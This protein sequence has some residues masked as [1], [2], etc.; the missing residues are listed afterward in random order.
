MN[1]PYSVDFE[2]NTIRLPT[3]ICELKTE[4]DRMLRNCAGCVSSSGLAYCGSDST[5]AALQPPNPDA[6]FTQWRIFLIR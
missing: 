6:V 4:I 1:V 3:L 5:M 2:E